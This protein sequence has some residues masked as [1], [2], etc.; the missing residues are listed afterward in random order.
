MFNLLLHHEGESMNAD[1]PR[2]CPPVA[3]EMEKQ[4]CLA[5]GVNAEANP[6][7]PALS[8]LCC[9]S[10]LPRGCCHPPLLTPCLEQKLQPLLGGRLPIPEGRAQGLL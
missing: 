8:Q 3:A 4:G 10:W 2:S 7:P 1:S 6:A 5:E 9:T